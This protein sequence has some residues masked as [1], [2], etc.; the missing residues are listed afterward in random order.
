MPGRDREVKASDPEGVLGTTARYWI[1]Q[2]LPRIAREHFP[3][4]GLRL[5]DVGCGDGPYAMLLSRE[6]FRGSYLG[7]D[8][9]SSPLWARRS[10]RLEGLDARFQV[11]DAHALHDLGEQFNAVLSVTAFEHL[12]DDARVLKEIAH[13]VQPRARIVIIVPSVLGPWIWGFRH[14][15]RWYSRERLRA[16]ADQAGLRVIA[17]DAAGGLPSFLAN[18]LWWNASWLLSVT[19]RQALYA[20]YLGDK[21]RALRKHRFLDGLVGRIQFAHQRVPLGRR[22]HAALN[23][24]L[25]RADTHLPMGNSQW[26]A[27]LE[28]PA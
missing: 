11:R 9:D 25:L 16:L 8:I 28:K 18:A 13:V 6:G 24:F 19:I 22:V 14:A 1:N 7:I 12:R 17:E 3:T 20:A 23:R 2:T 27:V 21:Q 26:L 10:G 5:L 4:D 15:E